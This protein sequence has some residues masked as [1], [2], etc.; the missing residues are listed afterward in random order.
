[1]VRQ[2]VNERTF[3]SENFF[4]PNCTTEYECE[5]YKL[6]IDNE[7]ILALDIDSV[8]QHKRKGLF[9]IPDNKQNREFLK[10]NSVMFA[11][12]MPCQ[13]LAAFKCIVFDNAIFI[14]EKTKDEVF[15]AKICAKCLQ[16]ETTTIL[17]E[18]QHLIWDLSK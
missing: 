1:M 11:K 4:E 10:T 12:R 5:G 14:N 18:I 6:L 17:E 15:N 13:Q 3:Y 2:I 9:T 8:L 7:E 16:A